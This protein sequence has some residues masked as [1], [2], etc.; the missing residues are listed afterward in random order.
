MGVERDR[1]AEDLTGRARI[2]D[3]AL[4]EFAMRGYRAATMK[5]VAAAAG[6][7]VGLVQHHYGSKEGLRRAC[8]EH[9]AATLLRPTQEGLASG[10][11]SEP[12]FLAGLYGAGEDCVRYIARAMVEDSGPAAALFDRSAELAEQWLREQNPTAGVGGPDRD[13]ALAAAVMTAMHLGTVVLA[14]HVARRTG[15][16]PLTP[17]HGPRVG[18]AMFEVYAAVGSF[19]SSDMG[20]GVVSAVDRLRE[21]RSPAT[22]ASGTARDTAGRGAGAD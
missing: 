5:Q 3:A 20:Q 19:M 13:A 21:D 1:P 8:D 6:V 15:V 9:V 7:S 14:G 18:A 4:R 10:E 12:D 11:I 17:A 22:G 16:D 2:R